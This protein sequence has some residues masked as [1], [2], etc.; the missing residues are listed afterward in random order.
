MVTSFKHYKS[1]FQKFA[2]YLNVEKFTCY[3]SN[4]YNIK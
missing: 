1:Q 2:E 4:T 3:K